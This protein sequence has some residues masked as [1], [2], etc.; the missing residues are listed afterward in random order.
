MNMNNTYQ[1]PP[2]QT[3]FGRQTPRPSQGFV[4]TPALPPSGFYQDLQ[5]NNGFRPQ[6][7]VGRTAYPPTRAGVQ[8]GGEGES[9][10]G[11]P[12]YDPNFNFSDNYR[13]SR[14]AHQNRSA[15]VRD[16]DNCSV[17]IRGLPPTCTPNMLLEQIRGC[18][19]K[20][21]ALYINEPDAR[22]P[23]NCAAKLVFFQRCGVDWLFAQIRAGL[24]VIIDESGYQYTPNAVYN[25]IRSAPMAV[26]DNRSR[27]LVVSGPPS[28]VSLENLDA[29]FKSKFFYEADCAFTLYEDANWRKI[30]FQFSS[31]RCQ[32]DNGKQLLE[33]LATQGPVAL[34]L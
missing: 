1:R 24:W 23:N 2:S 33:D 17:F 13:G 20:I 26:T 18:G 14:Q 28:V 6:R 22:N 5:G 29:I 16:L 4:Q 7:D 3:D 25:N 27:V 15:N 30:Q 9:I 8:A 11:I 19:S 10:G 12:L 31:A 21:W 32:S 34:G